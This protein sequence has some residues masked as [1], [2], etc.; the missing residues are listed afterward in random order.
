[1]LYYRNLALLSLLS[2]SSAAPSQ[3]ERSPDAVFKPRAVCTPTAGGSSSIDDVPAIRKAISSCGNGGTIVFPAGS[4]YYLNSVLDLAGCSNC[5][6]QVEGLLMFSGS[7]EYWGGKTAMININKINALKLRSLTGSGVID[8]NGQNAYDLFASNSDYE[9]P[10]LLYITGGSNIEV[11]GLRQRNPPNVFNSVKG[12]AK[13]VTFTNLRMDATSRS[14]NPPKN[15]DGFDIGSSTHVT[16]SSVSVS[17]DD[18]CVAL[19]PGCNYVT[20]ENVTCTGSHGISVGSLGKSSA[21]TVQNVY[22]HR[23]TMIDSTKAAGIKTYPSGN[24][25]GLSTVKNVTFSDFNVRGCDY[26]F[27]IQSCYGESASYCASHPGNAILQ[28]IIVKGFSGTT[29]GKDDWV[30][31]DLNCGA[32]GTCDVSMSDF[33]VK[34]PS[35]KATVLCANTPSSLGVTCTSGASG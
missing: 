12:D 2:L 19:K 18:D 30:V 5:D 13:D 33:S 21:D 25:H 24:G 16:I 15:T 11:S 9:R 31:A 28:D 32:R 3:V 14:D 35:G 8:G 7:T 22:A 26:A 34:A 20:V 6:I 17:N 29:S 23:I 10:T 27:Q 1:M 4:T